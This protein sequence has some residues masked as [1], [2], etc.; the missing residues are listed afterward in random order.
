VHSFRR[1]PIAKQRQYTYSHRVR[2][3]ERAHLQRRELALLRE[4]IHSNRLIP[5]NKRMSDGQSTEDLPNEACDRWST[6]RIQTA[7]AGRDRSARVC[8]RTG[9]ACSASRTGCACSARRTGCACGTRRTRRAARTGCASRTRC[10]G[11]T[12]RGA[13]TGTAAARA[14]ATTGARGRRAAGASVVAVRAIVAASRR[15]GEGQPTDQYQTPMIK[16]DTCHRVVIYTDRSQCKNFLPA[17]GKDRPV[18][19][20]AATPCASTFSSILG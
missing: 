15:R 5:I 19:D 16:T 18:V 9:C 12:R 20:S 14:R 2:S 4:S 6:E 13:T 17:R 8:A 3:C 1:Q 7:T 11:R 10:A